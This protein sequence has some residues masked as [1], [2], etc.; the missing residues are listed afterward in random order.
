VKKKIVALICLFALLAPHALAQP[1]AT[2]AAPK[3]RPTVA[4][5]QQNPLLVLQQFTVTDLQAALAD[6]Q[7]QTP[8]DQTAIQCYQA[9]I[10]FVNNQTQS[11]LPTGAGAFQALQ[12]ARDAKAYIS[13]IQ[14]PTG[15]LAALNLACA[16]LVL[17][18][19]NTLL[20]MGVTLGIV[21]NPAGAAGAGAAA[22]GIPAAVAAFLNLPKL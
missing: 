18:V 4:Q 14:S 13:N 10:P 12:K 22:L 17:D 9:L 15:P 2:T 8:P 5:V 20:T 11:I 19:Q 3:V 16:P 6:A 1:K 7:A 21:A